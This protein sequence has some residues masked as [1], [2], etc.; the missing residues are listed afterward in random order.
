MAQGLILIV[1]DEQQIGRILKKALTRAGHEVEY[2]ERPEEGL[3]LLKD[4]PFDIVVTDL[5]MP[6]MNGIEFLT[7]ARV[8]RP[9]CEVLVMTGFASVETAVEALKRGAIDYIEKPFSAGTGPRPDH[10]A[11]PGRARPRSRGRHEHGSR[12]SR[13]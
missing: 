7:R 3:H 1:D 11:D 12:R 13:R 2:A 9:A 10:R 8:I 4:R 5:N 6:K